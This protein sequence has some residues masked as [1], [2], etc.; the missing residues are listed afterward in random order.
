MHTWGV[1]AGR[2][3]DRDR[4]ARSTTRATC[5]RCGSCSGQIAA[6][7]IAVEARGGGDRRDAAVRRRAPVPERRRRADRDLAGGADERGQLLRRR[8]WARRRAVHDRRDRVRGDRVRPQDVSA[9]AVLAAI[10][11]G[12]A[13]GFLFHNFYPASVFMGDSGAN[14]LGYLL[15]V[16]AVVGSLKTNAVVALVVPLV[17]LAVPFLDTGFVVAKRLKYR[18]KPWSADANHFHHRMARIGFSQRKTVAYLYGWTLMLAGVAVALRFVPYSRPPRPLP[19]R[20]VAVMG[21]IVVLALAASIYLVYVLEILKFRAVAPRE[22]RAPTRHHRVRD[23]RARAAGHRD[24]RV[25]ARAIVRAMEKANLE[26]SKRSRRS[27]ARDPRA[28]GPGVDDGRNQSL[29]EATVRRAARPRSIT[30][31]R[32]RSSTTSWPGRPD[33]AR[34][35]GSRGRAGDCVVIAPG[36]RTSCGTWARAAR[37]AVLLCARLLGRRHRHDGR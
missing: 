7:V 30:T 28:G 36:R 14:L 8:R 21:A 32:R 37:A 35:R 3:R 5:G 23:R 9:A 33:A 27:T 26:S 11:A 31:P 4:R 24:G 16:A 22:L 13:L 20:L 19:P 10:T 17:I 12:A 6:A 15:G 25:R 29:A 2:V 34:R 18:R 1:L